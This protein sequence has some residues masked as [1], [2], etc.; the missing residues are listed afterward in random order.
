MKG[1]YL[2]PLFIV[3]TAFV[4]EANAACEK[5][6]RIFASVDLKTK[7]MIKKTWAKDV[8]SICEKLP[9]VPN[10]NIEVSVEKKNQ[11]FSQKIFRSL[12]GYWDH[13]EDDGKWSGGQTKLSTLEFNTLLPQ[14]AKGQTLRLKEIGTGKILLEQKL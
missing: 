2:L 13:P 9:D 10:A 12:V 4:F 7:K 14:W 1:L 8:E 6:Q 11:K 3:C 5:Y